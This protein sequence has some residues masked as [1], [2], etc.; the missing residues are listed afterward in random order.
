MLM[1]VLVSIVLLLLYYCYTNQSSAVTIAQSSAGLQPT[2]Y[3]LKRPKVSESSAVCR[4]PLKAV[5][6]IGCSD[7][8][9]VLTLPFK[10][11]HA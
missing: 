6:L 5:R 1:Q 11:T 4:F 9:V 10:Y 2:A 8:K 3:R 7:A